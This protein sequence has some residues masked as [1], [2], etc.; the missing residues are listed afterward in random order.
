MTI[1]DGVDNGIALYERPHDIRSLER[2]TLGGTHLIIGILPFFHQGR[3]AAHVFFTSSYS[4]G[5]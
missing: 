5:V 4:D 2:L 1:T 3:V